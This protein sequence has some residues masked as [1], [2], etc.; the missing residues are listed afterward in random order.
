MADVPGIPL[1]ANVA[2]L[3]IAVH[4][5]DAANEFFYE[6]RLLLKLKLTDAQKA[7]QPSFWVPTPLFQSFRNRFKAHL[8]DPYGMTYVYTGPRRTG[9]TTASIAALK[10]FQDVSGEGAPCLFVDAGSNLRNRFRNSLGVPD[11]VTDEKLVC[12]LCDTLKPATRELPTST[13]VYTNAALFCPPVLVIDN[14]RRLSL[15]DFE[16]IEMLYK[17]FYSSRVLL[18]LLTDDEKSANTLCALNGKAR[19]QPLTDMFTC[20]IISAAGRGSEWEIVDDANTLTG[21]IARGIAWTAQEWKIKKLSKLV[22]RCYDKF[23][24]SQ[25]ENEADA[26]ELVFVQEGDLPD[27]VIR[28]AMEIMA[29]SVGNT[30]TM[31]LL[32]DP[33]Y[34]DDD[35]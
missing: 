5:E 4:L 16:L 22:R 6:N 21:K 20:T 9:K 35:D 26:K 27:T 24:W 19:I 8:K 17:S 25:L 12:F 2:G 3:K 31:D 29:N 14:I 32:D 34:N 30:H 13:D 7:L 23:D 33:R 11:H 1:S 28:R 18:F 10:L 15:L